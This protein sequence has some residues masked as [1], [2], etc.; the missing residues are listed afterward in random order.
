MID[1]VSAGPSAP[2]D[3]TPSRGFLGLSL[4]V[5][6]LVFFGFSFTYWGP[7]V[8]GTAAFPAI[9]HLH[10][11]LWFGW[12]IL[13]ALQALAV[14]SGRLVWHRSVGMASVAYT[15]GLIGLS[16][17]LALRAIGR[18]AH[19][20]SGGMEA[21]GTIIPLS[22]VMMFSGFFSAAIS[23][24]KR[25]AR[26]KRLMFLAALVG[27][28]PAFARISIGVLGGPNVPLI[29]QLPTCFSSVGFCW[30]GGCI[31]AFTLSISGAVWPSYLFVPFA[32][33]WR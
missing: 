7:L 9:I 1:A 20:A 16:L 27:S 18:D 6:G 33:R 32:Y 23:Q 24:R 26:H 17:F 22:Q 28:T 11:T 3:P 15:S 29:F 25:T 13:L 30:T 12:F 14:H 4:L 10:A 5:P 19:L 8:Q 2:I 31:D 21:V